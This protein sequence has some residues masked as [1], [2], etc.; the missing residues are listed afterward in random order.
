MVVINILGHMQLSVVPGNQSGFTIAASLL[1]AN[2]VLS[3]VA[4]LCTNVA[5]AVVENL[6]STS[7]TSHES[8]L[9]LVAVLSRRQNSP[10][11]FFASS[12]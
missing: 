3:L 6:R 8:V 2:P 5:E 12:T 4:L 10:V 11:N 1:C 7:L 9:L